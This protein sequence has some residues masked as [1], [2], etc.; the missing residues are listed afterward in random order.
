MENF[1]RGIIRDAVKTLF[2]CEVEESVIQIQKTRRE[3]EGDYTLVV[4][5]LLRY[6]KN[7]P[8]MTGDSIGSY[9]RRNSKE[10][11]GYN[12]IKGFLNLVV[13]DDWWIEH[14]TTM[15]SEGFPG[16]I[17]FTKYQ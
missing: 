7:T 11:T 5:P 1:L 8:E 4:F 12:V 3:F 14:F 2:E 13:S 17:F 16:S 6:S 10:I 15:S 9:L